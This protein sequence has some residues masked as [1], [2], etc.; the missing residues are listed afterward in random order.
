MVII[1]LDDAYQK[2]NLIR[3]IEYAKVKKK[4]D[5]EN[6][7][8]TQGL[9]EYDLNNIIQLER[10]IN[11]NKIENKRYGEKNEICTK[12][13]AMFLKNIQML[14]MRKPKD[15]E[16]APKRDSTELKRPNIP[17]KAP[18]SI[19]KL[20]GNLPKRPSAMDNADMKIRK[21]NDN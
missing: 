11:D 14:R 19:S 16:S 7:K 8:L 18:D 6:R 17:A 2:M 13:A 3:L 20:E 1:K 15:K 12:T 5:Y 9:Y 21:V 10:K 4:E